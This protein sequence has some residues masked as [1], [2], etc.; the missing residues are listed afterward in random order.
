HGIDHAR[1]LAIV[2][3]GMMHI[4][5]KEKKEKILQY[6]KRVWNITEGTE[7]ERIDKTIAATVSFFESVG[8]PTKMTD[9]N[10][11]AETIDKITSRFKK[12]GF[13]LG[14]KSDIGPKTIKLILE[15]RL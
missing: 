3:P 14:E 11:P 8:I 7:D 4:L 1:T 12:R 6:G 15:N 5:R 10:V 9:Y 13:K 2:L